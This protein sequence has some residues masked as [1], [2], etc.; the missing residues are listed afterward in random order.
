MKNVRNQHQRISARILPS[1][2]RTQDERAG[3]PG[4]NI[5]Q[6][7]SQENTDDKD[8]YGSGDYYHELGFS[9]YNIDYNDIKKDHELYNLVKSGNFEVLMNDLYNA[10][11]S[12]NLE[13]VKVLLE[14]REDKNPI[15]YEA[16]NGV[17]GTVLQEAA[18]NGHVEIIKS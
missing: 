8:N 3:Q 10:V 11:K 4:R 9:G 16:P 18:F 2:E 7:T 17:T 13:V 6:K 12:G 14:K 1:V 5:F 15:I